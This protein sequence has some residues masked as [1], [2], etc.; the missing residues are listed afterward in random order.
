MRSSNAPISRYPPSIVCNRPSSSGRSG[1][2]LRPRRPFRSPP[3][4]SSRY[5][6]PTHGTLRRRPPFSSLVQNTTRSVRLGVSPNAWIR[7]AASSAVMH[8]CHRPALRR[9]HP[10]NPDVRRSPPLHPASRVGISP[11][12]LAE[13]AVGQHVRFHF[14][15]RHHRISPITPGRWISSASSN[16]DRGGR[17]P[18]GIHRRIRARR[19]AA[20]AG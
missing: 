12:T 14:Q 20:I 8:R 19:C 5:R 3:R 17:D 18:S 13:S 4:D 9:P 15:V 6:P 11:I 10:R 1:G 16:G 7:C 2:F